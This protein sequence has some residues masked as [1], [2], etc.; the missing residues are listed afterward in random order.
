M[1][2]DAAK[3]WLFARYPVVVAV[4]AA[5]MAD[6][7]GKSGNFMFAQIAGAGRVFKWYSQTV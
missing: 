5:D 1:N 7:S 3:L 4:A 6:Y 2:S